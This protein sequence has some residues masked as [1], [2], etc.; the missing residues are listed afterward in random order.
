[1]TKVSYRIITREGDVF[2]TVSYQEALKIR[3][4]HPKSDMETVYTVA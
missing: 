3:E 2:E 4:A 1:M